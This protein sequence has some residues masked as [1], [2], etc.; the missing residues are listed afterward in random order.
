MCQCTDNQE[1]TQKKRGVRVGRFLAVGLG[2]GVPV[3][4]FAAARSIGTGS[5]SP[6]RSVTC[7]LI[8]YFLYS[9]VVYLFLKCEAKCGNFEDAECHKRCWLDFLLLSS[10]VFWTEFLCLFG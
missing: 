2:Y 3:A 10:L 7:L 1:A 5:H 4:L 9:I 8:T 6:G